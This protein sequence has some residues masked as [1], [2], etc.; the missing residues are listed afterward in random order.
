VVAGDEE[1]GRVGHRGDPVAGE[2]EAADLVDRAV[3]V[4]H[5]A[6]HPEPGGPLALE[7]E[8][9]VHQV[10][11]DPRSG[12]AAVLRHVA[13]QDGRHPSALR[14]P[15]EGCGHL[16]DLGDA[17]RDAVD[18]GNPDRLDGVDDEE[19]GAQLLDVG[20]HRAEV[21][22]GGEVELVVHTAAPVGPEP[23]LGGRLL[24]GDVERAAP[25]AGG[26]RSHLEEQRRLPDPRLAGEQHHRTRNE[27]PAEDPV[28]LRDTARS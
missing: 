5:C 15:H 14:L 7:L 20:E 17:A 4:L 10:L 28:E 1:P 18:P 6:H 2:V 23:D 22:L 26:L 12:D 8:H 21:G 24:A 3:A 9:D 25:A 16:L 11:E 13:D 19:V 27:P